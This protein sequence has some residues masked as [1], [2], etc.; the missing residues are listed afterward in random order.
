MAF[1]DS[2]IE[3]AEL[4]RQVPEDE[5]A[6]AAESFQGAVLLVG[7]G[8]RHLGARLH[9]MMTL[10]IKAAVAGF[11]EVTVWRTPLSDLEGQVQAAFPGLFSMLKEVAA[12]L[13]FEDDSAPPAGPPQLRAIDG[14]R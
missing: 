6:A 2:L 11:T 8:A 7:E 10:A 12:A 9:P 14:D 4:W 5:R 13:G 1:G 3:L